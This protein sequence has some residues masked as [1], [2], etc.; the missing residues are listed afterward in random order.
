MLLE[1]LQFE[2]LIDQAEVNRVVDPNPHFFGC[3]DSPKTT[4][5]D[6]EKSKKITDF[7][8]YHIQGSNS[9]PLLG[10]VLVFCNI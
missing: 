4:D 9:V 2:M 6:S 5:P 1:S 3:P 8:L 10:S 7:Y